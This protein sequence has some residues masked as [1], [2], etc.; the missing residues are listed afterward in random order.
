MPCCPSPLRRLLLL[1]VPLV[2]VVSVADA[3]EGPKGYYRMPALSGDDLVFVAEGDLWRT[4]VRGG[5]ARRLTSH[6]G[7][8]SHPVISPDGQTVAYAGQREGTVD[9]YTMP[10]AGGVPERWTHDGQR[11]DRRTRPVAWTPDGDLLY[12]TRSYSGL[13]DT[14]LVRLRRSPVQRT[15]LPLSQA[16]DGSYADDGRLVFTRLP[17]QGS[18]TRRYRGGTAEQL[19]SFTEGQGEA[20]PLTTDFAGRSRDPM[21]WRDR[22]YFA[23]ERDGTMNLWS[24]TLDGGDLRQHTHHAV[25]ELRSPSLS[26]GRVVYQLGADLRLHDL[27][28][29]TD[30][31]LDIR[32]SSDLEQLQEKWIEDPSDYLTSAR[33]GPKGEKV[34]L[35]ARGEIFV[36]PVG[37]GRRVHLDRDPGVRHRRARLMP[38][39]ETV[40]SFSDATGE[41][42]LE[43]QPAD[44]LGDPDAVTE[45]ADVLMWRA[46]VSPDGEKVAFTDRNYRLFVADVSSGRK[47]L[48]L[49][50]EVWI[51]GGLSWSPDSRYLAFVDSVGQSWQ[52]RLH[53]HDTRQRKTH[54]VTSPRHDSWSPRFSRD[55]KWLYFLSNRTFRSLV[56]S[57]WGTRQPDPFYDRSA[58]LYALALRDGLRFPFLPA[59]ELHDDDSGDDEEGSD[60]G[61]SSS[62]RSKAI[63]FTD[64]EQ[65]LYRLPVD[66]G[67]YGDLFVTEKH[68]YF[69]DDPLGGDERLLAVRIGDHEGD[70]TTVVTGHDQLDLSG[71]GKKLLIGRN[72][73]LHVVS[74][75]GGKAKLEKS[76]RVDL[77]GWRFPLSPREEWEQMYEESW[78]LLRDYHYDRTMHGVDWP[79]MRERYRPLVAR[80]T[81]RH[82]LADVFSQLIGELSVL[83]SYVY[84][85]DHRQGETQVRPGHLG[86]VL[87]RDSDAGGYRIERIHRHDPDRPELRSPLARP[88]LEVRVGEVIT[89]VDGEDALSASHLNA[90][91]RD[92]A[93]KQVRLE[94]KRGARRRDVVVIPW[95]TRQESDLRYHEWQ[96]Q[97]AERVTQR[98]N[99]RI[100]YIHLRA[101]GTRDMGEWTRHYASVFEKEALIVDVRHN[102]GGNIDSW[103][104]S[105]LQRQAWMYWK[106]RVGRPY[107]NMHH[108]FRGHAACLIDERTAS[109]GEAF[110]EGFRRI[111]LGELIGTR[112]WGGEVWLTSSN[113]LV[114]GGIATAAEFG[115]YGPEGAWLIEGHGVEPDVVVDNLPHATYLGSDLQLDTAVDRLLEKLER[116]P[117]TVPPPPAPKDLSLRSHQR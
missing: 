96:L 55:G 84:G 82:E 42:E 111:G 12:A 30:V 87:V 27:T 109:D 92:K 101:M 77:S 72:G 22:V 9:V 79:A 60:D 83:H 31:E 114:D 89:R 2:G 4:T 74:A 14:Q 81:D 59:D 94:L 67:N 99:G 16:A 3:L 85:G 112:T 104:L 73:A 78:R 50:S 91:L 25:Y 37:S 45:G 18:H 76:N 113:F 39:G 117:V 43:L 6:P 65:R 110:A 48:V 103:L 35:T 66:R 46:A 23:S 28:T 44:G 70:T 63:D 7:R 100:G 108:A 61:E 5:V 62:G 36:A 54:A 10:L 90:L 68:L 88:D 64:I 1:L 86:A 47:R 11:S 102:G 75:S 49:Q 98:S 29:G 106:S 33:L 15:V 53:V 20:R 80:V 52:G 115:V 24:M 57:P 93:G 32:L 13:P 107:W 38:D 69:T 8:E 21:I 105:R 34:V 97:R 19:W 58:S 56:G 116:E 17:F 71:N 26:R 40:L 51:P 95:S 41:V